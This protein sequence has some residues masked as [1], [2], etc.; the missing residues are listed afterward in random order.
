MR[1]AVGRDAR[2][3]GG[4]SEAG[5]QVSGYVDLLCEVPLSCSAQ[6]SLPS[7]YHILRFAL[8]GTSELY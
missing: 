7:R 8:S 3:G 1:Q 4:S 6:N 5:R 2:G